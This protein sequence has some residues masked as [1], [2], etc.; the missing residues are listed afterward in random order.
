AYWTRYIQPMIGDWLE[1]DTPI[2]EIAA[3]VD[4]LHVKRDLSGFK[5]D[6]RFVQNGRPQRLFSKL[7][8]SIGG[9]YSWRAANAKSPVEKERMLKEADYAFR[10]AFALCP[11]SPE[12]VFRYTSLLVAQGQDRLDDAIVVVETALK[13]EPENVPLPDL[14]GQLMK[15]KKN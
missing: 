2:G 9:V 1:Y 5:G 13:V 4:K 12:V 14:L 11:A 8:S 15:M 7:R 6:S 10:Q 3:F